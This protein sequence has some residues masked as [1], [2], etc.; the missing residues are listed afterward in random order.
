MGVEG[1]GERVQPSQVLAD[2]D[3]QPGTARFHHAHALAAAEVLVDRSGQAIGQPPQL[4]IL[5][6]E[7][8]RVDLALTDEHLA[9]ARVEQHRF[10]RR[11]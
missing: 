4:E 7:V 11:R 3:R 2:Q 8:E 9:R 6:R 10:V 1:R 5:V